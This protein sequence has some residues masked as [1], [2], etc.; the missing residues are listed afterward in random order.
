MK[1]QFVCLCGV[2]WLMATGGA[3]AQVNIT[4]GLTSFEVDHGD[5][6][7]EVVRDQNPDAVV[8]GPFARTSRPCPPFCV[9]PLKADRAVETIGI[10]EL[11][12]FMQTEL[13][14]GEGMLID[15]RTPDWYAKGTIPGSVNLPYTQ[16][17]RQAGAT[18]IDLSEALSVLG[19]TEGDQGWDFSEA[20]ELVL[21]CN[22]NWC[23]QSP[24]AI[25]GLLV[26]G[27]PPEKLKY[28]RGGMEDWV[29]YGLTTV[30]P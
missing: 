12:S 30:L 26:E 29:Q 18:E 16:L 23:G 3:Q 7:I 25:R 21:W 5:E 28:Y 10:R 15:A 9:Q 19:V 1:N 14:V 27:Y 22:G 20:M 8:S 13:A 4:K 6:A 24:A 11:V 17:N 2:L